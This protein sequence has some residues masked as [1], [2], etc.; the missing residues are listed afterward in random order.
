VALVGA[1]DPVKVADNTTSPKGH[2]A[3][4]DFFSAP[5]GGAG[6]AFFSGSAGSVSGLWAAKLNGDTP[7]SAILPVIEAGVAKLPGTQEPITQIGDASGDADAMIFFAQGASPT[8]AQIMG[9]APGPT[10]PEQTFSV[11]TLDTTA[12][13]GSKFQFLTPQGVGV[14]RKGGTVGFH[15]TTALGSKGLF[16][17]DVISPAKPGMPQP[18]TITKIVDNTTKMPIK[19]THLFADTDDQVMAMT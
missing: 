17:A 15:A 14:A 1:T 8:S 3:P 13:D 2:A 11:A 18:W 16:V 9:A 10:N 6:F 12:P 5:F 19:G 4:F 7:P